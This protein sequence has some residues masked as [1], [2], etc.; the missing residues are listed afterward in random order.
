MSSWYYFLIILNINLYILA[1]LFTLAGFLQMKQWA[2]GKHKNYRK[3]FPH[4]PKGRT[5]IV[6]FIC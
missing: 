3:E 5:P 1:G 6:P 2:N 4:Y